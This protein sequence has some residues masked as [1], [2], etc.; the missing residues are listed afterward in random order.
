MIPSRPGITEEWVLSRVLFLA[1]TAV[2]LLTFNAVIVALWLG[3]WL[4][5][6]RMSTG[7]PGNGALL[8]IL[9]VVVL[10]PEFSVAYRGMHEKVIVLPLLLV[11]MVL[12]YFPAI[13]RALR[14]QRTA[15]F[16]VV[17][18]V[19]WG[20]TAYLPVMAAWVWVTVLGHQ[21]PA[22]FHTLQHESSGIKTAAPIIAAALMLLI[23]L[24]GLRDCSD[25][26]AL[27]RAMALAVIIVTIASLAE[28]LMRTHFVPVDV[29]RL[30]SGTRRIEGL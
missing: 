4:L 5:A 24:A 27:R 12:Y 19:G 14:R 9:A 28:W 10:Y 21:G 29:T 23:A 18:W 22:I 11:L 15:Q 1:S 7:T 3:C 2:V 17:A 16:L 6:A 20:L 8:L 26:R 30:I 13:A 25:I